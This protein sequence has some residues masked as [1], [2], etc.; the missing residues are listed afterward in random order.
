MRKMG[1][2]EE[3]REAEMNRS[4]YNTKLF[5]FLQILIDYKPLKIQGNAP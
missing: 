3:I 1:A 5:V 2:M 4:P